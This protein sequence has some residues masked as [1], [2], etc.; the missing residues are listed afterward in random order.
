MANSNI[1]TW[2]VENRANSKIWAREC[3]LF[4]CVFVCFLFG[5]GFFVVL[6]FVV[7]RVFFGLFPFRYK[8]LIFFYIVN[9][10]GMLCYDKMVHKAMIKAVTCKYKD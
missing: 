5:F 6:F 4:V 1:A 2:L 7:F 9:V 10:C 3:F 8:P